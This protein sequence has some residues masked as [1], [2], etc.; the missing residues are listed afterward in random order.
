M[1]RY[2]IEGRGWLFLPREWKWQVILP[3]SWKWRS[4]ICM[5]SKK[6]ADK[7]VRKSSKANLH[8][9]NFWIRQ[10]CWHLTIEHKTLLCFLDVSQC[11]LLTINSPSFIL[12]RHGSPVCLSWRSNGWRRS[13]AVVF[14]PVG[15]DLGRW[16]VRSF[17]RTCLKW[18]Q[19]LKDPLLPQLW[20]LDFF[21]QFEVVCVHVKFCFTSVLRESHAQKQLRVDCSRWEGRWHWAASQLCWSDILYTDIAYVH[22]CDML[23][24]DC[25]LYNIEHKKYCK[26]PWCDGH[27]QRF[28][29][30]ANPPQLSLHP[31]WRWCESACCEIA[32]TTSSMPRSVENAK[33]WSGQTPRSSLSF[34]RW[35][36]STAT[37]ATWRLS[38][39]IE[40]ERS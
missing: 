16:P 22:I 27:L 12:V 23:Y 18:E 9:E 37:L 7:T 2:G 10:G 20:A 36:R 4:G 26:S 6:W 17:W 35:C 29:C 28:K 34:C 33:F 3:K 1:S 8:I 5:D 15:D 14:R 25:D 19:Q 39:T 11:S 32:W 21:C 31:L 13:C 30:Q 24:M 38:T 40:Q